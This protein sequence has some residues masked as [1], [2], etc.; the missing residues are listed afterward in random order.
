[1]V[2]LVVIFV[3]EIVGVGVDAVVLACPPGCVMI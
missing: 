3:G 1:M 2:V